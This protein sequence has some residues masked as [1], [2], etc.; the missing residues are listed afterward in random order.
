VG[1]RRGGLRR[2]TERV[3]DIEMWRRGKEMEAMKEIG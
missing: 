3:I 1:T 2:E